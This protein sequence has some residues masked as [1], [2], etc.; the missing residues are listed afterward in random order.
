[1]GRPAKMI[2]GCRRWRALDPA[3]RPLLI[4]AVIVLAI[5]RVSTR[6]LPF[7]RT[8]ALFGLEQSVSGSPA[9]GRALPAAAGRPVWAL[10]AAATRMPRAGTCLVQALGGSAML[11]RR[12]IATTIHL[13]VTR[14][15]RDARA[16]TAHAWLCCDDTI[17]TGAAGANRYTPLA[18]FD[19]LPERRAETPLVA[20]RLAPGRRNAAGRHGLALQRELIEVLAALATGGVGSVVVLKGVPLAVRVF[21]SVAEREMFDIDLLVHRHEVTIALEGLKSLG[22]APVAGSSLELD[23]RN[24]L[25]LLRHTPSGLMDVDLHWS[26]INRSFGRVDEELMWR[27]TESFAHQGVQCLVFD[28]AMTIVH[29]ALHYVTHMTPK[30]LRDF[31]AAWNLWHDRVEP[32]ELLGLARDTEQLVTLAIAFMCADEAGLLDLAGPEI[33]SYRAWLVVFLLHGRLGRSERGRL[34]ARRVA[35]RPDRVLRELFPSP[36]HMRMLYGDGTAVQVAWHYVVRP[37]ECAA[38]LA[39]S[40]P[41]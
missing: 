41:V 9:G 40:L 13:G 23:Y 32:G 22:Y 6:V 5:A 29:L 36:A 27:H 15:P 34:M 38:K 31:A 19:V 28:P 37:F 12:G 33:R 17:V 14:D 11:G 20:R 4:E 25:S 16:L 10:S 39:R 2:S 1:V 21:G 3:D 35:M 26:A 7:R 8:A 30:V 24:E 18:A